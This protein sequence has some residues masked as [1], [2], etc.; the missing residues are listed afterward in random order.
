[1]NII[2]EYQRGELVM[3]EGN[4]KALPHGAEFVSV[5]KKNGNFST[6]YRTIEETLFYWSDFL[7][8]WSVSQ[9][10][11]I[12]K[13]EG[14]LMK[15]V[16]AESFTNTV[17][18]ELSHTSDRMT[19][20]GGRQLVVKS[21]RASFKGLFF[22]AQAEQYDTDSPLFRFYWFE[23]STREFTP[24][25]ETAEVVAAHILKTHYQDQAP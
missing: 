7:N 6:Y 4:L 11:K 9:L 15:I 2:G 20:R 1:M 16:D 23:W 3:S 13:H 19:M 10:K 18:S 21:F 14:D 22:Y 25:R 24:P 17:Q 5:S 8:C 12:E